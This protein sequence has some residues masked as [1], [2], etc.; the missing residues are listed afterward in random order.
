VGGGEQASGHCNSGREHCC[1]RWTVVDWLAQSSVC[2]AA[3]RKG[4]ALEKNN[5]ACLAAKVFLAAYFISNIS[6]A[7]TGQL[8]C[9]INLKSLPFLPL[10]PPPSSS[11]SLSGQTGL[12]LSSFL[13]RS[14][15]GEG[16]PRWLSGLFMVNKRVYCPKFLL[17]DN[18][19]MKTV[20]PQWAKVSALRSGEL[21][22]NFWPTGRHLI[23]RPNV[24]AVCTKIINLSP[25]QSAPSPWL[26][27]GLSSA[28]QKRPQ[29][30][31]QICSPSR[32]NHLQLS[33][34]KFRPNSTSPSLTL[35][36][37]FAPTLSSRPRPLDPDPNLQLQLGHSHSA[38]FCGPAT[39]ETSPGWTSGGR[40]N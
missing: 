19:R 13:A 11:S 30:A 31:L 40:R 7:P 27:F 28:A 5:G 9:T 18:I 10:A 4:D 17:I 20:S 22:A 23:G 29:T 14:L 15:R 1:G 16:R 35:T 25:G 3:K 24:C 6:V 38:T 39:L 37:S 34:P 8:K 32:P 36:L 26:A 12:S 21:L 33:P 2:L